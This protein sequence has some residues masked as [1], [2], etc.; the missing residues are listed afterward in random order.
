MTMEGLECTDFD[1]TSS[2][3][4]RNFFRKT[5]PNNTH[6]WNDPEIMGMSTREIIKLSIVSDIVRL[7]THSLTHIT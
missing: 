5:F 7:S 1:G 3:L 6:G 4:V 2:C